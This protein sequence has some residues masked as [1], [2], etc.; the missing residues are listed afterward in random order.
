MT[1][2]YEDVLEQICMQVLKNASPEVAAAIDALNEAR[3]NAQDS[4]DRAMQSAERWEAQTIRLSAKC[5][6]Y[7]GRIKA[8][9]RALRLSLSCSMDLEGGCVYDPDDED[10]CV[11]A[12][13]VLDVG[14]EGGEG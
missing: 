4:R 5:N 13:R 12:K 9:K 11:E 14:D 8:L 7:R 6:T 3:R 2:S 10:R 1:H